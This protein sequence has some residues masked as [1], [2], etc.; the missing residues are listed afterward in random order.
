MRV[1]TLNLDVVGCSL[2]LAEPVGGV[3][4]SDHFGVLADLEPPAHPPGTGW[5]DGSAHAG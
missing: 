4:A 5:V 2:V 1:V 3:W